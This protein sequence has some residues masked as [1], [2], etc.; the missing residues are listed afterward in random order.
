MQILRQEISNNKPLTGQTR[1]KLEWARDRRYQRETGSATKI[2]KTSLS[3]FICFLFYL[4]FRFFLC[5]MSN[6]IMFQ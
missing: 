1:G 6:P 2:K 4:F 5:M 3:V